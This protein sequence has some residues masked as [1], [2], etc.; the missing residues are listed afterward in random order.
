MHFLFVGCSIIAMGHVH[1][2]AQPLH[3]LTWLPIRNNTGS[4]IH[5]NKRIGQRISHQGT[6]CNESMFFQVQHSCIQWYI[7]KPGAPIIKAV[8]F[9]NESDSG[10]IEHGLLELYKND[11]RI[12]SEKINL[13]NDP[14]QRFELSI[15]KDMLMPYISAD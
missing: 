1:T 5:W 15:T 8:L 3:A 14:N 11:Q 13:M 7:S 2:N 6:L 4:P 9:V 10:W 12:S